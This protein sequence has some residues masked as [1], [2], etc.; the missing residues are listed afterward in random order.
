MNAEM[1]C[2]D[3]DRSVDR[4]PDAPE[5]VQMGIEAWITQ[6]GVDVKV[7]GAQATLGQLSA[8]TC[9]NIDYWGA[10]D[11]PDD[12]LRLAGLVSLRRLYLNYMDKPDM[13]ILA[14][15]KQLAELSL[16]RCSSHHIR[17]KH[18]D[19][20]PLWS[21]PLPRLAS[22]HI[23]DSYMHPD[24]VD[25]IVADLTVN[26]TRLTSLGLS[27]S[28]M[29]LEPLLALKATLR[30]L[31]LS[32]PDLKDK[33][34]GVLKDLEG[35][36]S[37]DL[38]GT[39]VRSAAL[40]VAGLTNL[41][42]LCLAETRVSDLEPLTRLASLTRLDLM[43]CKRILRVAPLARLL[44]PDGPLA[45]LDVRGCTRIADIE[46]ISCDSANLDIKMY[47]DSD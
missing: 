38:S 20:S 26:L 19:I 5:P 34:I 21:L 17:P 37:L 27:W 4:V 42:S 35:L 41:Q 39:K 18:L 40:L 25:K 1:L 47:S 8:I 22:L 15:L 3:G 9:L 11:N 46:S 10:P 24:E 2:V 32:N 14:P 28:R 7:D 31:R 44:P 33:D 12:A 13:R 30:T 23:C 29:D 36:T 16:I 6:K 45:S 43:G